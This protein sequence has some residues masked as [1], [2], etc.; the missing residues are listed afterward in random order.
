MP[1]D[2]RTSNYDELEFLLTI[3]ARQLIVDPDPAHFLDWIGDAGPVLAPEMASHVHPDAGPASGFFR[4]FGMQIYNDMPLPDNG[5]RPRPLPKPQR[6]QPCYCGSGQKY[7]HCCITMENIDSPLADMNLLY[8][9]L[10]VSPKRVLAELPE[11]QVDTEALADVA[12]QWLAR[13]EEQRALAL[14]EPWFKPKVT[15]TQRQ[16]PMFD[17][18]MNLYMDMNKPLKRKRLL[19]RACQ[20][21]N[22]LLRADAWQRKA[23]MDMDKGDSKAAWASFAAAQKLDPDSPNLAILEMTLLCADGN[24]AQAKARATFWLA[25]FKRAGAAV[26]P[27]YI[28]LLV[29]CTRDPVAALFQSA[30]NTR[31]D[32]ASVQMLMVLLQAAPM[33]SVCHH[34]R[35]YGKESM[36]EPHA[37]LDNLERKW[38]EITESFYPAPIRSQNSDMTLWDHSAQWLPLLQKNPLL[39][40]SFLVLDDLVQG[41]DAL[42]HDNFFQNGPLAEL[43]TNLLKRADDVLTC[44]LTQAPAGQ[45]WALSWLMMENRPLLRLLA[46]QLYTG[47]QYPSEHYLRLAERLIRLNPDDNQGI[48]CELSTA[49]LALQ[50]PDKTLALVAQ[51]PDDVL[52]AL[53]LNKLLAL[54]QVNRLTE[55]TRYLKTIAPRFK[56][57]LD[58]L[59]AKNPRKPQLSEYGVQVGGKDEAWLYRESTLN[60]WKA[61]G[62]LAWLKKARG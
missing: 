40:N 45:D 13:G 52:C 55:A 35:L 23:T 61:S 6:N 44:Q 1:L 59:L 22:K 28:D 18:L 38:F 34:F 49:Y 7:K 8:F 31:D 26:S 19:E 27:D 15:L 46:R 32:Y 3:S 30:A 43:L 16:L 11:S 60:L 5:Y 37:E 17:I 10:E 14:L 25:R 4:T 56:I 29:Q 57:A 53:P 41:I 50:Q 48:R 54:Y 9:V 51:Y 20:A 42:S 62:A 33:P 2:E 58:M 12:L 21:E 39:W 47:E 24:P 36:L